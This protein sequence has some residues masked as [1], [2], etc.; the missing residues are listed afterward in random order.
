MR[1]K[2]CLLECPFVPITTKLGPQ[3]VF[4]CVLS[5]EEENIWS[6]KRER[7]SQRSG[8]LCLLVLERRWR[9]G[10][11]CRENLLGTVQKHHLS[12]REDSGKQVHLP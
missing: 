11:D 4:E 7:N 1:R 3:N 5:E 9:N 10:H 2:R 12:M 8:H 6:Q